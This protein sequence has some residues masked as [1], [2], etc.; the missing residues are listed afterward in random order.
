M[1]SGQLRRLCSSMAG[2]AWRRGASNLHRRPTLPWQGLT[3]APPSA[4]DTNSRDCSAE[5][6]W[7]I[8]CSVVGCSSNGQGEGLTRQAEECVDVRVMVPCCAHKGQDC[9]RGQKQPGQ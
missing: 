9:R 6:G 3:S 1:R 2:N 5:K 7:R 8:M 4:A